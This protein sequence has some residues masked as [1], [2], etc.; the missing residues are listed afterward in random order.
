MKNL[1]A[2]NP[3]PFPSQ[4]YQNGCPEFLFHAN[5]L[6]TS[7]PT[8]VFGPPRLNFLLVNKLTRICGR[9]ITYIYIYR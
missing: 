3:C 9:M 1:W 4:V 5:F 8:P 6:V 7:H 2:Y